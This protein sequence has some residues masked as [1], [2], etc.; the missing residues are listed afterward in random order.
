MKTDEGNVSKELLQE[1]MVD[2][3]LTLTLSHIDFGHFASPVTIFLTHF[4]FDLYLDKVEPLVVV[5]GDLPVPD[6]G[7]GEA[8]LGRVRLRAALVLEHCRAVVLAEV[9]Q[10]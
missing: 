2:V 5:D 8:G 10:L 6:D 1:E 3:N 4:C 9:L 7:P